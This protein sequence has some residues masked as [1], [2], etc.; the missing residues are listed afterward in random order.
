[1]SPAE[2]VAL[3]RGIA[4]TLCKQTIAEPT[5]GDIQFM[6]LRIMPKPAPKLTAQI[7]SRAFHS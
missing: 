7:I 5:E 3:R 2:I 1:M 4:I 6:I